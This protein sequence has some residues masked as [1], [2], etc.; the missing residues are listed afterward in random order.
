MKKSF[1][2][3]V[4]ILL[5][6]FS[7]VVCS[8][9]SSSSQ[10]TMS[11]EK[12]KPG[13]TVTF[14]YI[15][16]EKD[17]A[18]REAFSLYVYSYS[19]ELPK[20]Q[21]VSLKKS[22]K[23]WTG[24]YS[25][26][27][28]AFGLV[29]KVKLDKDNED[30]NQGK[31]YIFAL[32]TPD[33]KVLPGHKAG[34]A[35]AYTSWG[36]LVGINQDLN[37]ALRLT[38]ED[39][40]ANPAIKK[41]FVNSYLRLLQASKKE[42]WEQKSK[43]FLD[44][45]SALSDLDD[46]TLVTL[47]RFYAQT[48]NQEKAM[49]I[50]QQAQKNPKGE[51]FQ[52]QAVMQL[53]G[54]QDP[55]ARMDFIKKF[56]EEFPDS[57]YT[58]SIIGMVTQALFQ[59]KKLEEANNFLQDNRLKAQPYYF[60]AV[61][62]QAN[63]EGQA[64]LALKALDNGISLMAEHLSNPDKYKPAYYTEEEWREEMQTSLSAMMLS[65]KGNLLWKQG[66]LN[67]AINSLRQAYE[68]SKG[69][70]SGIS[71]DYAKVLLENKNYEPA[72]QVLEATA[73]KGFTGSDIMDLLQQA[74]AGARGSNSGW[75]EYRTNLETS[76]TAALRSELQ[77]KMIEQPAPAFELKDLEGKVVKLADYQGKVVVLDFWA[78][79]C[80]PCLGSFPGMKKLVEEYQK[81]QSVAFVFVNTW[82][83]EA[84]KEQ[85]V[86]EFLAKNQYPF[87]V[88]MDTEDKVVADYGVSG[89]PTKFIIDPRGKI[90]FK[91]IGFEGDTEKMVKEVKL[92]IELARGK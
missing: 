74:Y 18:S 81:D 90:R 39:F 17:L 77:K 34:L 51:F 28:E 19:R 6:A 30:N 92:M 54:I 7:L 45:V 75:E 27:K 22:G 82:Q 48:G 70:Q 83:D 57:K 41:Q 9:K 47:Y 73:R 53:Q 79:W 33:G 14:A 56:Q 24:T 59:E 26:D 58:E 61:A 12:A 10:L 86:K 84:N 71:M 21:A 91:S 49:A 16:A 11:P 37:E 44:E 25:I 43:D 1:S 62:N 13:D 63:Q 60:Y 69:E 15:P 36:Q 35:L 46:S 85:V 40:L 55:K 3:A 32:Y 8:G 64:P 42:G 31:G 68:A 67:E 65:L 4:T 52:I 20:V 23:K 72:L 88:L 5:V 38:E 66:Q 78:T 80:G 29:A 87:Y 76:A 2:L 50:A 89:I